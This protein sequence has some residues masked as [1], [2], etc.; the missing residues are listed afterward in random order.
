M[1]KQKN[2]HMIRKF[3]FFALALLLGVQ[4]EAQIFN[5]YK[6]SINK[7]EKRAGKQLKEGADFVIDP[8]EAVPQ[9][10]TK[11][12]A[13]AAAQSN[14]GVELLLPV[15]LQNRLRAE[16][17]YPVKVKIADTGMPDHVD[18]RAGQMQ[19]RNYTSD[20]AVSDGNGH[21]THVAGIICSPLGICRPL[22]DKGLLTHTSIKI[23]SDNGSGNFDWVAKAVAA[24]RPDDQAFIDKGGFVVYN[25]SFGGG[26]ALLASVE[27]E[28]KKSTDAGVVFCFAAGNTGGA[29]VNYPGNGKFSIAC[30]SLDQGLTRSSYSTT[31]PEVWSAMPGRNINSTYKGQTY[32]V[33]SGTSMATP[34][35]TGAVAIA[36]SKWGP[37][38]K[39][40]DKVRAYLAWCAQD[41][42][43][44]GKDNATGWGIEL[45]KNILDRDPANTPG[46]PDTPPP[47]PDTPID[48]GLITITP[49]NFQINKDYSVLWFAAAVTPEQSN[50]A[51]VFK[52]RGG[53]LKKATKGLSLTETKVRLCVKL[54]AKGSAAQTEKT[55][56]GAVDNFFKSR[57]FQLPAKSD[58]ALAAYWACYFLEMVLESENKLSVDVTECTL[59]VGGATLKIGENG[60]KHWP[61]KQQIFGSVELAP[62]SNNGDFKIDDGNEPLSN[63]H[64][65]INNGTPLQNAV[66][67]EGRYILGTAFE[68]NK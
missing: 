40:L 56:E 10:Q 30:A 62:G 35:L 33:L 17:T 6:R 58:Q 60:L 43:P 2:N 46:L 14:W 5:P 67:A 63:Y 8:I 13:S 44:A 52:I 41:I 49:L 23:L 12:F 27:A 39:G 26:T 7:A 29:G 54:Q 32:A 64:R 61:I 57:G 18:L 65:H 9:K 48:T 1:K 42:T 37:K 51:K 24:E 53:G 55:V 66:P 20:A 50:S 21:G 45:I 15:D 3:L 28:L 31:G 16:C 68:Q 34:F 59:T 38:L 22:V 25:G 19:G 4:A 11:R 36:F 47:P